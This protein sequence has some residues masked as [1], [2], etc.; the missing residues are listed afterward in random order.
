MYAHRS[1]EFPE[2]SKCLQE[3]ENRLQLKLVHVAGCVG[4]RIRVVNIAAAIGPP[5]IG[6]LITYS[7]EGEL[8]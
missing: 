3:L 6:C 5:A 4:K 1:S 2:K 7:R 8:C